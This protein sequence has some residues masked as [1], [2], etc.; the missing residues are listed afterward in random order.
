MPKDKGN[1]QKNKKKLLLALHKDKAKKSAE[2]ILFKA[3]RETGLSE[4]EERRSLGEERERE[5]ERETD[6]QTDRQR[7]RERQRQT[8]R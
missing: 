8:E 5:R 7:Q 4:R 3:Q 2:C 1:K 6:R